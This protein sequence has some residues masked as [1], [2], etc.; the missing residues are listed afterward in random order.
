MHEA[1]TSVAALFKEKGHDEKGNGMY[2]GVFG[3][4]LFGGMC[5]AFHSKHEGKHNGKRS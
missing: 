5:R 1:A 4:G 2:F 3:S